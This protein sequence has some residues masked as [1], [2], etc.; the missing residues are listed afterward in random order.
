MELKQNHLA[1]RFNP[2]S[3]TSAESFTLL[4]I[5][6]FCV[7]WDA[8]KPCWNRQERGIPW[9]NSYVTGVLPRPLMQVLHKQQNK[10]VLPCQGHHSSPL[11]WKAGMKARWEAGKWTGHASI[12]FPAAYGLLAVV[13]YWDRSM[14][15]KI[16]L[17]CLP[18]MNHHPSSSKNP[19][20]SPA[21]CVR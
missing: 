11:L 18:R 3:L 13:V 6:I 4:I 21:R 9:S 7:R 1:G 19:T 16:T 8:H 10:M 17:S 15:W 5:Y 2:N 12:T 14:T 20:L